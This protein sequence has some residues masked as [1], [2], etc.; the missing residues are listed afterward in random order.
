[1]SRKIIA[2]AD[3]FDHKE[4]KKFYKDSLI[5]LLTKLDSNVKTSKMNVSNLSDAINKHLTNETKEIEPKEIKQEFDISNPEKY[6]LIKIKE[7]CKSKG[8]VGLSGK[9]KSELIDLLKISQQ[10]IEEPQKYYANRINQLDSKTHQ[11]LDTYLDVKLINNFI[12]AEESKTLYEKIFPY[13]AESKNGR[14]GKRSYKLFGDPNTKYVVKLYGKVF[15]KELTEWEEVPELIK[16]KE[17]LESITNTQF[18]VCSIQY[19]ESG[20]CGI[21]HHKDKEMVLGTKICGISLGETR[22]LQL[23]RFNDKYDIKIED[24]SLYILDGLTNQYWTHAIPKDE[25]VNG[26]ISLTFRNYNEKE[27]FEKLTK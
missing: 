26:R 13:F 10:K 27:A 25:T 23:S 15:V 9:K 21:D 12:S 1:M 22:T 3:N 19:Y 24:G 20:K 18:N 11:Y 14:M 16:I 17:K 6:T 5:A 8:L 2:T 7:E 4:P